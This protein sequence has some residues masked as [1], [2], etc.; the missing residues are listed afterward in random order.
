MVKLIN[1]PFIGR[2]IGQAVQPADEPV[3]QS[4]VTSETFL[5]GVNVVRAVQDYG[6]GQLQEIDEEIAKHEEAIAKLVEQRG[7]TL[8]LVQVI[9]PSVI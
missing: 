3:R 2:N 4:V 6:R 8:Q 7:I 9:D 1:I 5:R